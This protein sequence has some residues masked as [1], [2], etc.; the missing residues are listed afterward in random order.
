MSAKTISNRGLE[1]LL[2][3]GRDYPEN[4]AALANTARIFRADEVPGARWLYKI[5][6]PKRRTRFM[7]AAA[8]GDT[9]RLRYMLQYF[10]QSPESKARVIEMRDEDGFTALMHA[11]KNNHLECVI[12]LIQN[13]ANVNHPNVL[14]EEDEDQAIRLT[15]LFYAIRVGSADILEALIRAGA[16]V[17]EDLI[18]GFTALHAVS[19]VEEHEYLDIARLLLDNGADV[20][21]KDRANHNKTPLY[22]AIENNHN[23]IVQL[24]I[25]RGADINNVS[26]SH[27][28][29]MAA[30]VYN[31]N[32][33][34]DILINAGANINEHG[35][36]GYTA[37]HFA[38]RDNN[39]VA[40]Q[41]LLAA[42]ADRTLVNNNGKTALD[43]AKT[44]AMKALLSSSS[45]GR[46]KTRRAARR[47]RI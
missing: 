38:S 14:F 45:G 44:D 26:D 24:L 7:A 3:V 39:L 47:R 25:A 6:G 12:V 1:A 20:N 10:A 42:G 9:A 46:R 22:Y 43:L 40:A 29:F 36:I 23:N 5:K 21:A 37:L 41:K 8:R 11:I 27:T 17:N 34:I 33:A 32:E 19:T 2:D 4:T 16:V 18:N 15:P 28:G 13:G 35:E 30:I 31:N